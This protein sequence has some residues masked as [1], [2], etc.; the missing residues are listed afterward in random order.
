[1]SQTKHSTGT[2]LESKQLTIQMG[3]TEVR[4]PYAYLYYY[5]RIHAIL[6]GMRKAGGRPHKE[7]DNRMDHRTEMNYNSHPARKH[8][9]L[10]KQTSQ[11]D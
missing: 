3:Q 10:I 5:T 7:N 4:S 1:M 11:M 2:E 9:R 6:H 8:R